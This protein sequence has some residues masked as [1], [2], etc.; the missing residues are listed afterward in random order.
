[1]SNLNKMI[2]LSQE[3]HTRLNAIAKPAGMTHDQVLSLLL[4]SYQQPAQQAPAIPLAN[5]AVIH[6]PLLQ[7][8]TGATLRIDKS[9]M[10]YICSEDGRV[11]RKLERGQ[12]QQP[13]EVI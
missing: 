1:M 4:D 10:P 7:Y 3:T 8:A 12:V 6:K 5:G 2:H 9:G 11:W 13:W